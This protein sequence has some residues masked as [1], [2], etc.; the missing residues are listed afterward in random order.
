MPRT[1]L[2]LQ[3]ELIVRVGDD[4]IDSD[5]STVWVNDAWQ[6]CLEYYSW[7]FLKATATG[8][9]ASSTA[10]QTFASVFSVTDFHQMVQLLVGGVE[11]GR[12]DWEDK[13]KSGWSQK[14]A[15]APD[16]TGLVLPG[17]DGGSATLKY[18]KDL[19]DLA[20]T[21]TVS[22]PTSTTTGVPSQ[23]ARPF[24]EGVIARAAVRFFQN[25]LKPGL[26]DYW[27]SQ[28]NFYLDQIIDQNIKL[29]TNDEVHFQTPFYNESGLREF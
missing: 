18:K 29:S 8:T 14:Y 6:E 17:S 21:Q 15:I 4:T 27:Q 12:I 20:G 5:Q 22:A 23:Y 2:Q 16:L 3:T 19:A 11:Y 7:P 9:L 1:L 25:A 24:E 28:S 26:A 10:T 13:D